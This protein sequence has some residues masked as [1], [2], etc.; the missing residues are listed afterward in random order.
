MSKVFQ[1]GK[2]RVKKIEVGARPGF[3]VVDERLPEMREVQGKMPESM[4][5]WILALGLDRL[6]TR[7]TFQ[8]DVAGGRSRRGGQ[9][10]DFM[11]WTVPLPTP[12]LAQGD[13]WHGGVKGSED[14]FKLAEI[15][16][17]FKGQVRTPV[18]VWE[19][20][21]PDVEAA[22]TILKERVR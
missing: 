18:L 16:R 22:V 5:E 9:V 19:H 13:Y 6:K 12:L 14:A 20:E 17:F 21:A 8:Y 7:Y 4:L 2:K 11:V 10:I 1:F 3:E 15:V